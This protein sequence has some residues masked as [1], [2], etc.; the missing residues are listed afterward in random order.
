MWHK[1]LIPVICQTHRNGVHGEI[2]KFRSDF[3]KKKSI[4]G[5][6]GPVVQIEADRMK[7]IHDTIVPYLKNHKSPYEMPD[8]SYI[9]YKQRTAR[10]SLKENVRTLKQRC[11]KCQVL[12]TEAGF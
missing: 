12:L 8:L 5:R 9:P 6:V 3:E 4:A 1:R 7:M 11:N 10:V 2:H